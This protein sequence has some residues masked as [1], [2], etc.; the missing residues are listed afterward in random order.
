MKPFYFGTSQKPLFGLYHAPNGGSPRLGGIV[1]CYPLGLEY[2]RVHRSFRELANRLAG[3]GF[4]AL[5][6]DYYGSGDSGGESEDGDVSQWVED[7]AMALEEIRETSGSPRVSLVGVRLGATLCA[8]AGT[9]RIDIERLVLWDPI[10]KGSNYLREMGRRHDEWLGTHPRPQDFEE[11]NPPQ[12]LL[13][14][15][16]PA[17]LREQLEGIDLLQLSQ[18]P[19]RDVLIVSSDAAPE[20]LTLKDHL[21][22]LGVRA[23][24]EH[25]PGSKVYLKEDEINQAVVPHGTLQ[26]ISTWLVET[27]S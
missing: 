5:R 26:S 15:P 23:T 1:L 24:F 10:V 2:L 7:I 21:T 4:H 14:L 9:K 27:R 3:L 6:F 8:L 20:T 19:S 22:G 13:G 11:R 16:V 12:E 18:K 25:I 17:R